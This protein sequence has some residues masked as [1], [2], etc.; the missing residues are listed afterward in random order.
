MVKS[1][2]RLLLQ[3]KYDVISFKSDSKNGGN[4]N[5]AWLPQNAKEW[6]MHYSTNTLGRM[7]FSN[8]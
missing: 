1:F 2:W 8:F 7:S 6:H 4:I 5:T 3:E